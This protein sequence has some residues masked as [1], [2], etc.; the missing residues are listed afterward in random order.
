MRAFA[1]LSI[2]HKLVFITMLTNVVALLVAS[3]F[4]AM[5]EVNSLRTA[6]IRDYTVL[7]KVLGAN[8]AAPLIFLAPEAAKDSLASL[9]FEPNV[10]AAVIYDQS[11][12]VFATYQR[13]ESISFDPPPVEATNYQF[14]SNHLDIFEDIVFKNKTIGALYIQSDLGRINSLL[15]EY[16]VIILI[17]LLIC[18]LLAFGVSTFLQPLIS[19]PILHLVETTSVVGRQGDYSIRARAYSNDELGLLVKGFNNMLAQIQKRDQMLAKHREHL[20]EQVNLRT[21]ELSL[22]NKEL[23][24]TVQDL[25]E[26][27]EVAEAASQTKSEF[28]ANMSHE[29][30]TPMNAVIGMAGLLQETPLS[31][32]QRDFVETIRTSS[33]TLLCLINDILD[34]S[35]I[36]AGKLEL[37]ENLFNL[38]ECVESALDLVAPRAAEKNLELT[39]FFDHE[40][41][42]IPDYLCGDLTRLRQVLVNLLTNA[43]KFTEQGEVVVM[44]SARLLPAQQA[45]NQIELYFAV[46]DTGIGIPSDRIDRLFLSFSQV[47][48]SMTRKYGGTGLGLAISK[49]LC[50]LMKG[51]IWID[52]EI[53]KGSTF[54]FTITTTIGE[55]PNTTI[56]SIPIELVGKHLLI[57]DDNATNLRILKLQTQQW[58]MAAEEA[59]SG[60][61]ALNRL[62]QSTIPFD[63]VI[64]DMQMPEMDGLTLTKEIRKTYNIKE[65]PII[66]LTSLGRHHADISPHLF[67]AYLTKPVKA[68][69]LLTVI[70]SVFSPQS[71]DPSQHIE[72]SSP[73][74]DMAKKHPLRILLA[75]DNLTNQ[76]VAI[77]LLRRL[78]YSVDIASNGKEAV[79]AVARQH[80]DTI[81]M[82]VQMPEMDGFEATE[83]IRERWQ[84][85]EQRPYI[86]A[87]TAHA[88]QGYREKCLAAGMD[89][90]VT[91]PIRREEL[92]A[93][94]WRSPSRLQLQS[95]EPPLLTV[96]T[97]T[98][99]VKTSQQPT[100]I[101]NTP[102][103]MTDMNQLSLLKE[104]LQTALSSLI[105]D[106]EPELIREL[107]TTYLD[108]GESLIEQ[109]YSAIADSSAV[110][111]ALLAQVTH[112]LKSSSASLGV[113]ELA[114]SCKEVEYQ[115]RQGDSTDIVLKTQKV[116]SEYHQVKQAIQSLL[117]LE[118]SPPL[119]PFSHGTPTTETSALVTTTD[120]DTLKTQITEA[121]TL[122]VGDEQALLLELVETYLHDS[123]EL[124]K[125]MQTYPSATMDLQTV[126]RASHSLKSSSASLGAVALAELCRQVESQTRQG[127]TQGLTEKI[128]QLAAEYQQVHQVLEHFFLSITSPIK[129][130]QSVNLIEEKQ[131]SEQLA[132]IVLQTL[133]T[134]IG[135]NEH[136]LLL[137]LITSYLEESDVAIQLLQQAVEQKDTVSITRLIHSFKANSS[138]LGLHK[139]ANACQQLEHYKSNQQIDLLANGLQTLLEAYYQAKQALEILIT[140]P[141]PVI[142]ATSNTIACEDNQPTFTVSTPD[143]A[144]VKILVVDDQPYDS[145]LVSAYLREEGYNVLV[146]STGQEAIELVI[147]QS[148]NIV[149][150]D[151]MMPE[152]N[153]FEVCQ[154][155]KSRH[156]SILTPVVL[157]T[158]LEGRTE[159]IKGIQAGADEF[160]SKPINREELLAR[161]RSLLRYQ[162]ARTQLEEAQKLQLKSVFKRYVSPKLVDE[163][164]ATP[165]KAEIVLANQQNRLD[166]VIMFADL[167]GFTTMSEVLQP[168]HV[169]SLLNEFFT[170]LTEIGYQYDG[171]IF[172]MAGDCLL[173]GFGV[174]FNQI[175]AP[176]RAIHAAL[177][178]QHAFV[179]LRDAWHQQHQVTVGLGIGINKGEI[180]VGN[181]G[182]PNYMNY[183]VIGDTVNVA[184]R[185]VNLASRGEIILSHSI[186]NAIEDMS[187]TYPVESLAPVQLKGKSQLQQIYRIVCSAV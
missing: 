68:A 64:L 121:L 137:E 13:N 120:L 83:Q 74:Q 88:L 184:S 158:A 97:P 19:R 177:D 12:A 119:P 107:M 60:K 148:P 80:Y 139:L 30:R 175:D 92:V 150:S 48:A 51:K 131:T 146:A 181:V 26:A 100:V 84:H 125:N 75:E 94:L 1:N 135:D 72:L 39:A 79:E 93:A 2:R 172:N 91:K 44:V 34:F 124:V 46:K 81:L 111:M 141:A 89:D 82:D 28:L 101:N 152:M 65:L 155:I 11:G 145:L 71:L 9:S 90:Y 130:T 4:F 35:K 76:K 117:G 123:Q 126:E 154:Q 167:R 59:F 41:Q 170:M 54:Y 147:N 96:S 77:H 140:P 22:T 113:L 3:T 171:T 70:K 114:D 136:A 149:L 138:N 104:Q 31:A 186:F 153:G 105:G 47:D 174:P 73:D 55:N 7:A 87:M 143:P 86:V 102:T 127:Q 43:V 6:M 185:L 33:D 156:E 38:R 179:A 161:I 183:T 128:Q 25:Q 106:D 52:S 57:V 29:I 134:I 144:Q 151:V 122:L 18:S 166:G 17:I 133:T 103:I 69:Q 37:E 162:Y 118:I 85:F 10:T 108:G 15:L 178:M 115:C 129:T 169:V 16:A 165:E 98:T 27:K 53:G 56:P 187:L 116:I 142:P 112:S 8:S 45:D 159:R 99:P 21:A 14:K 42:Q 63:L 20:E 164:L 160:I 110:D 66:M 168:I 173:I 182:S 157:L 23:E 95:V 50:E 78:G 58:G 5:N 62:Q 24:K 109:L 49:H 180:I 61:E 32:Q 40:A 176:Q 132:H 36:D 67:S 163:I